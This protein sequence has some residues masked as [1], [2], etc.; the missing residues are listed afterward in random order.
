MFGWH[1]VWMTFA[2]EKAMV[3]LAAFLFSLAILIHFVLLSTERYNWLQVPAEAQEQV[4]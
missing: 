4:R 2:P 3:G 1:K